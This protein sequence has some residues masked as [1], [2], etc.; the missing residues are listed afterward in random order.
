MDLMSGVL[1]LHHSRLFI[2]RFEKSLRPP[3]IF[4]HSTLV[5]VWKMNGSFPNPAKGEMLLLFF[6]TQATRK[7]SQSSLLRLHNS[8]N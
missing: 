2:F 5:F 8:L 6:L 3:K 4:G 7:C 1:F